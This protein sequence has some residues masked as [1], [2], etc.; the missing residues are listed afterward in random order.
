MI[1]DM[2][3][4][5]GDDGDSLL[6]TRFI[7]KVEIKAEDAIAKLQEEDGDSDEDRRGLM[8]LVQNPYLHR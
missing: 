7:R 8:T 3:T 2:F 5:Y 6:S 1:E 4:V